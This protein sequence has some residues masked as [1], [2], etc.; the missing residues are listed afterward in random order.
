MPPTD[1]RAIPPI[2]LVAL[3]GSFR[4]GSL[5]QA[6]LT[7]VREIAPAAVVIR[8]LDLRNVPYYDGDL[9]A[10]GGTDTVRELD[11]L[12]READGLLVISPEYNSS[13]PAVLKNAIDWTSRGYPNAPISG[14]LTALMGASPGRSGTASA[15]ALL[16]KIL[17]RVG[18][19]VVDGPTVSLAQARDLIDDG[20]VVDAD[21]RAQIES[22]LGALIDAICL[23]RDCGSL[24]AVSPADVPS[25]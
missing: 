19:V 10:E 12:V 20:I 3:V 18:A 13:I 6:I 7:T 17:E 8:D 21:A 9:E 11:R 25:S 23:A 1:R 24:S 4:K 22:V 14:K 5:N 16:R 2:D 15:Q